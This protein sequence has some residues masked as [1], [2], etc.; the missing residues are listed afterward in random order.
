MATSNSNGVPAHIVVKDGSER[1]AQVLEQR[2][3]EVYVHYY[4]ADSRANE[5][6]PSP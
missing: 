6:I 2:D 1:E 5:W 4:G 3:G